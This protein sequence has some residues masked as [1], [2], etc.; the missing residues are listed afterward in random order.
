LG[1]DGTAVVERVEIDDLADEAVVWVRPFRCAPMRCGRCDRVAPG[2]D[3]GEGRRRWRAL[4]CGPLRVSVEADAPRVNCP[5]HGPT[6]IAVPW[7]RHGARHTRYF[8]MTVAWLARHCAKSMVAYLLRIGWETVGSIITR[9]MADVD[10]LG[11]DRFANVRRIGID[12]V[13]YQ[14]G[15]KYLVVVVD[16]ATGRLLWVG[17]GRTKKTLGGFFQALGEER[18]RRIALVSADGADW[19]ADMVGL[20][21]PNAVL[22]LDPFHVVSRVN[23]ALDQ[24]RRRV[25]RQARDDK[26]QAMLDTLKDSR[27][28]VLKN[29]DRLNDKQRFKLADIQRFNNQLYRGW[30]LKEQFRAVFGPGGEERTLLLDEWL[31]WAARCQ[32]PEFVEVARKLRPYRDD[33]ANTLIYRLTNA[34]VE[35]LNARVRLLI[36]IARGFRS[37]EALMALMQLHLGSYQPTLPG[38]PAQRSPRPRHAT[39]LA[40]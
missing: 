30:L 15:H 21:C 39:Q 25:V 34:V 2:Y 8:E 33:I 4:D 29:P 38:R 20:N 5:E 14:K 17:K 28:A 13:S 22:C 3:K 37:V 36:N 1:L 10:A 27:W 19:I 7:A 12:E 31:L 6:V 35:G 24:L 23:E 26:D 18:C 11:A 32:I 16:H 9:V 40:A